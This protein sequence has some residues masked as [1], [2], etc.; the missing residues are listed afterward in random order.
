MYV[1]IIT[2]GSV[3][4]TDGCHL[5]CLIDHTYICPID[6]ITE[7]INNFYKHKNTLIN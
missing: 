3:L 2:T 5:L 6:M 1:Y 4:A 7:I